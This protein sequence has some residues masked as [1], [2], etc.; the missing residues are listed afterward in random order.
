[1]KILV[2]ENEPS[3]ARG[4]QE[5]SLFD[6]TSRLAARG[7]A[8]DLLYTTEGDLLDEYRSFCVRV[9]RVGAYSIDRSRP[10]R[11]T[12]RFLLDA[13]RSRPAPDVVYANQYLDSAFARLVAWRLG[14]PFVCQL[15]LPPPDHFCRQ[16]RWGMSGA[17]RLIAISHQTRVD[18]AACGFREERIDVVHNGIDVARWSPTLSQ[19]DARRELDLDPGGLL[20]VYAGRLH[21]D[22]GLDTL[23]DALALLPGTSVVAIAG[24]QRE[25]L[26]RD[27]QAALRARAEARG[28][29]GRCRFIG[30]TRNPAA[31]Y[32]AADVTVVPSV[33]AEAFG[34]VVIE[35][36]ACGTPVVASRSGGI[37]EILT[38]EFERGLCPPG[39]AA[40]L[41]ARLLAVS[42][43]RIEDPGVDRRCRQH[44]ATHFD[45]AATANQIEAALTN[46]AREWRA[47]ASVPASTGLWL[48][49][50]R[51]A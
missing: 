24:Q 46:V 40:A 3:T 11:A 1:M 30:H 19:A 21:P 32:R 9:E 23:I 8:I 49:R 43:W 13:L 33:C 22:K 47:G 35:S 48:E 6:V 10:V 4:G 27:Y 31:L 18:Y 20:A 2:L 44:V 26:G 16:Y 37:P 17:T 42:E 5:L 36:M 51:D 12:A 45:I 29:A 7:H 25:R 38:G 14:R 34:R 15:R 28:V 50:G 41:A 39:D